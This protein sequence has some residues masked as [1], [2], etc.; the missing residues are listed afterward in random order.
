MSP[1]A[2]VVTVLGVQ[3]ITAV[4]MLLAFRITGKERD[5]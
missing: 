5:K 4:G 2:V 3:I 1:W